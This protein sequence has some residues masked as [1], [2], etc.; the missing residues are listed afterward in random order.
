MESRSMN[1][2][3][4]IDSLW[5]ILKIRSFL[6]TLKN[7]YATAQ[8]PLPPC[9]PSAP[10]SFQGTVLTNKFLNQ[11]ECVLKTS[12]IASPSSDVAYYQIYKNGMPIAQISAADPLRCTICLHSC[13]VTGIYEISAVD[14][15]GFESS[16]TRL[17]L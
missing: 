7:C 11:T 14:N 2:W 4:V 6:K 9:A 15:N 10:S 17:S 3:H 8:C 5:K 13:H 16:R 1:A 12:W